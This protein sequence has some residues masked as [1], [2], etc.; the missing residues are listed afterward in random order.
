MLNSDLATEGI[1]DVQAYLSTLP[2]LRIF[3]AAAAGVGHQASSITVLN[4]FIDL[5]CPATIEIAYETETTANLSLLLPGFTGPSTPTL[6]YRGHTLNFT[7]YDEGTELPAIAL[8]ATGGMD[9]ISWIS[10]PADSLNA[11]VFLQLQ[12]FG[13]EFKSGKQR[14]ASVN[15][16][17]V[18]ATRIPSSSTRLT[19]WAGDS[20]TASPSAPAIRS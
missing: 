13:W 4:R 15:E 8:C 7:T 10:N 19:R 12:P 5:G 1:E 14:S 6:T 9:H 17:W 2:G 18:R 3:V 11:D 20:S 16:V